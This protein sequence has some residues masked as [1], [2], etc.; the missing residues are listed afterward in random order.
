MSGGSLLNLKLSAIGITGL[1]IIS[2]PCIGRIV[3][4]VEVI[5]YFE[6]VIVS[7]LY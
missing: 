1:V 7:I 5:A 4:I 6:C 2:L 3:L